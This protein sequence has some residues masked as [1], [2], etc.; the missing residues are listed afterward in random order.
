MCVTM[1]VWKLFEVHFLIESERSK[2]DLKQSY[3][4]SST[5][6]SIK[7]LIHLKPS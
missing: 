4:L 6:V 2:H 1:K 5:W 3:F 7:I